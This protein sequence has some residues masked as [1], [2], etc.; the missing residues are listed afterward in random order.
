MA[1]TSSI[2]RALF[3]ALED[4]SRPP[5]AIADRGMEKSGS[6]RR[7]HYERDTPCGH[8]C[9]AWLDAGNYC[10]R[11]YKN[12]IG[13]R[14]SPD[15]EPRKD[16]ASPETSVIIAATIVPQ[17]AINSY[18]YDKPDRLPYRTAQALRGAARGSGSSPGRVIDADLATLVNEAALLAT[19]RQSE[20]VSENRFHGGDRAYRRRS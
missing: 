8:R 9:D 4:A 11:I 20:S 7:N 15:K 12:S 1:C 10:F 19:R 13:F 5:A 6:T 2:F 3:S 18:F 14:C 16:A 17:N